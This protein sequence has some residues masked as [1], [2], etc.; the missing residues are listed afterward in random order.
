MHVVRSNSPARQSFGS[1]SLRCSTHQTFSFAESARLFKTTRVQSMPLFSQQVLNLQKAPETIVQA[2]RVSRANINSLNNGAKS[3]A[4]LPLP[5]QNF[6]SAALAAPIIA[7]P[8]SSFPNTLESRMSLARAP[9][10]A[11]R[12][13]ITRIII[14]MENE[15]E[16]AGKN[17]A[18]PPRAKLSAGRRRA[19]PA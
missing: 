19:P 17:P 10:R 8:T 5:D 18:V 15:K 12:N 4:V 2:R 16:T 11:H 14:N 3:P 6:T 9:A 13:Q 7:S 1:P